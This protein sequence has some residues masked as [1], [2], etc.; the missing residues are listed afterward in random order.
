[1]KSN[2]MKTKMTHSKKRKTLPR[3]AR[4]NS[5]D[6]FVLVVLL[7]CVLG[8]G[9]RETIADVIIKDD[10]YTPVEISLY[11]EDLTPGELAQIKIGNEYTVDGI[12]LGEVLDMHS[13]Y[14]KRVVESVD[15]DGNVILTE[16]VDREHYSSTILVK[17]DGRYTE[18]GLF[19][20][21][22]FDL[23]VGKILKIDASSYSL[24]VTITEIPRI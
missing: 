3:R 1:M 7:L 21:E 9:L 12:R 18:N 4:L 19:I 16:V 13:E 24:T 23:Y 15:G 14:A 5:V 2:D 20:H 10:P 11:A 22:N 17:V 6:V 8:I